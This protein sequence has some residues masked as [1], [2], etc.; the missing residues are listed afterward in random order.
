[1]LESFKKAFGWSFGFGLGSV[2][3][4]ELYS[5]YGFTPLRST[6]FISYKEK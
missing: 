3:I 5:I 4:I 6:A 1:M 2:I